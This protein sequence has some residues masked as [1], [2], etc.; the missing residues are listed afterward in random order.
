[1]IKYKLPK[2][3]SKILFTHHFLL[4]FDEHI[5]LGPN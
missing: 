1:M 2:K 5:H 3:N 4:I